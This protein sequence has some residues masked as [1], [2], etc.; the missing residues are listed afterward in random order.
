MALTEAGCELMVE[1]A[2]KNKRV[3]MI[4][5]VL[6]FWPEYMALQEFGASG[7]C[8]AIRSATFTRQC[9]LPDWSNSSGGRGRQTFGHRGGTTVYVL[10]QLLYR[11]LRHAYE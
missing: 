5:Q 7:T 6:R 11:L 3:L 4:G 8:G 1:A 10:R 2:E 9:G